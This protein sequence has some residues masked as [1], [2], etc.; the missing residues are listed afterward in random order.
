VSKLG[1]I[2]FGIQRERLRIVQATSPYN[3]YKWI[4]IVE[5]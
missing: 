1:L 3:F 2:F 4:Q 5:N